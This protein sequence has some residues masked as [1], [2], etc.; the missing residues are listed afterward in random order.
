MKNIGTEALGAREERIL[1]DKLANFKG[2]ARIAI[3]HLAF[4]YPSRQIDRK[5]I[6]QLLRDFEG[7]GCKPEEPD[8]RIPAVVD[9]SVLEAAL[10]KLS[11][12]VDA[13][14]AN[15]SNPPTLHLDQAT[16]ECLH[17]QHRVFAAQEYNPTNRWWIVD[18]YRDG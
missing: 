18:L 11:M 16:L 12:S 8:H 7:E 15:A 10:A 6:D 17:G 2:T 3:K 5:I 4:P 1:H 9:N 13:F 14:R